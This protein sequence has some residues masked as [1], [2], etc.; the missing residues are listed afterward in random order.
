MNQ[1]IIVALDLDTDHEALDLV[2]K[3]VEEVKWYKVGSVLFTKYGS[4][5]IKT[6][7]GLGK[8]I[9]LDLKYHDIPNTVEKACYNAAE[10]GVD[11]LTVHLSGGALMLKAAQRAITNVSYFSEKPR[12]KVLGISVLTSINQ[13][14]FFDE[15]NINKSIK[16]HVH[17][18]VK[19]SRTC[20][21]DGI[22]CSPH[23]TKHMRKEFGME[24]I[25]VNPGV[26]LRSCEN[27]GSPDKDPGCDTVSHVG[28]TPCELWLPNDDQKRVTTPKEAFDNGADFIVIGRPVYQAVDPMA[29][30]KKIKEDINEK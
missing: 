4:T 15:F 27:C 3:L 12:T 19:L 28:K 20:L 1:E 6:L 8:K 30:I 24:M 2:R 18:L 22:V 21:T 26:R 16:D 13:E 7:K 14:T 29:V 23:E 25:I 17:D 9:M 10:L 11:M 5:L